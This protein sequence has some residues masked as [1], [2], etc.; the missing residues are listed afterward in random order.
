[1]V[2]ADAGLVYWDYFMYCESSVAHEI[3]KYYYRK[4]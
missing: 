4:F 2:D 3:E 1:M